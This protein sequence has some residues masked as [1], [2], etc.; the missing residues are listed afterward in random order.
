MS[1][2]PSLAA[3]LLLIFSTLITAGTIEE[4]VVHGTKKYPATDDLEVPGMLSVFDGRTLDSTGFTT[5]EDLSFAVP[6]TNLEPV[7]TLTG[8]QNFSIRGLGLNTSIPSIDPAVGIFI[9]GVYLGVSYGAV[10][11][12]F[13]LDSIEILRGPQ[14][15]LFG[16]NVTGGAILLRSRRPDG[17]YHAS[18]RVGLESGI[19]TTVSASIEAPFK[20]TGL[21]GRLSAYYKNDDGYFSNLASPNRDVGR[22]EAVV[23]RPVLSYRPSDKIDG[24]VIY[25][26][27]DITGDGATPQRVISAIGHAHNIDTNIDN[28]GSVDLNWDQFTFEANMKAGGGMITN[29]FGWRRVSHS[30]VSDLDASPL[31]LF[32]GGNNL[33][34]Q[35]FSNEIRY[36]GRVTDAWEVIAGV[37]Y[38]YQDMDYRESRQLLGNTVALAGGGTQQQENLGIFAVND[39]ILNDSITVTAGLR[40]TYEAKTADVTRLGGC[41]VV[42]LACGADF[43]DSG[44]WSNIAPKV[45]IKWTPRDDVMFYSHWARSFR[46]G[47]YSLR[48]TAPDIFPPG[49]TREERQDSLE[50]GART[51]LSPRFRF[52]IAGFIN[53]VNGLQREITVTDPV[54]GVIQG[55]RNT[56]DAVI[57]GFEIETKLALSE[58]LVLDGSL[59]YL[60]S[61]YADIR[62]DLNGDGVIDR[63]DKG[64][65]IPRLACWTLAAGAAYT[66]EI[67]AY[68][69]LRVRT[70]Y[71]YRSDAAMTDDNTAFLPPYHVVNAGAG[72]TDGSGRWTLSAYARNLTDEAI[73]QANIPLPFAA[74]GAPRFTPLQ[75]GRRFGV[76]VR[77]NY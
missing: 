13:D 8:V 29:I 46:S 64:L 5:L 4:V 66:R 65:R 50:V 19:Q 48:S 68:G 44:D 17:N 75:K 30:A 63:T 76:E 59:G 9:D 36:A 20:N 52:N 11:D 38:F 67:G 21:A 27:G 24:T 1:L 70:D 42:T 41:N 12:A 69:T 49:P 23:I 2:F 3:F 61:D 57:S 34:Q 37:Y 26:H 16:R 45:G 15:L 43:S 47:G 32:D 28:V 22:Q 72:F 53:F 40:Y 39:F 10:V 55:I 18:A 54:F 51:A 58:R 7:G 31:P 73:F 62:Y 25:E 33:E 14:G 71:S 35:Q 74:L 56:A 60:D 77:Y 6:N